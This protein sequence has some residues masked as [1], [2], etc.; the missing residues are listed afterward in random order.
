MPLLWDEVDQ[1]LD[2]R[3][4]TIKTAVDRMERLGRDPAVQVLD[5]KPDL[6]RVLERLAAMMTS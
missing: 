2:P 6:A 1:S 5:D 3:A 4:F